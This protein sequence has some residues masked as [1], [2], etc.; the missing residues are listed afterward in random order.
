MQANLI[1]PAGQLSR[2]FSVSAQNAAGFTSF[3]NSRYNSSD[4][5]MTWDSGAEDAFYSTGGVSYSFLYGNF[6]DVVESNGSLYM[7]L[8]GT[9]LGS[10]RDESVL[11]VSNDD[12]KNW[13][14]RST[15]A[16]Y[17]SSL[18]LGQMGTEG[19]SETA[20]LG[21]N[22]G[23]L[24]SVF[25]TGQPFPNSAI[26]SI[27]PSLFWSISHDNGLSWTPAKSLGVGGVFP[28]MRKLDDGSV[29]LTF[30]RYRRKSHVRRRLRHPLDDAH[31]YLQWS[32][33]RAA[34]HASPRRR[35][36]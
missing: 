20:M 7:S 31:D 6:S 28:L 26:D 11:F 29:A 1:R 33:Q 14:R 34:R 36:L 13:T 30:G 22:N 21:L 18:N 9:R 2:G 35:T 17:T 5:G 10:T 12:G 27:A 32:R 3:S 25:R 19:P 15:I 24:L 8:Y 16:S 4:G 23:D